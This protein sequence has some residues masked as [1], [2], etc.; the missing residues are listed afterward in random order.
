MIKVYKQKDTEFEYGFDLSPYVCTLS[1]KINDAWILELEN[2]LDDKFKYIVENSVIKATTP[3]G[4][5]L[6]RIISVEKND[7]SIKANARPIFLDSANEVFIYDKRPTNKT[8]QATLNELT[9][10]TKYSGESNIRDAHTA[11][12]CMKNLVECIAG[13]DENSFLNRWGGEIWYDDFKIHIDDRLGTDNNARVEFGF[14]LKSIEESID[15]SELV[16][17]IIPIAFNGRHL[18]QGQTVDSPH[19]NKYPLIYIK[20]IKYEYIKLAEDVQ[21]GENKDGIIVCKNL[22]TLYETL[23]K[24]AMKDFNEKHIDFPKI[25]YNVD[26]IDLSKTLEYELIK[27]LL[28]VNLGDTVHIKHRRLGIETI[29]RVIEIEYDCITKKITNMV[30]GDYVST[31]FEK[32]TDVINSAEKVINAENGSVMADKIQGIINLSKT[33]LK[34]QKNIAQRQDVRAILFEDLDQSSP[35]FGA[36]CIGTQG[37]QI[38]KK[39]T[40]SNDGWLWNTAINFNS[41]IADYIVTGIISDKNGKNYWN[42]DTGE[43]NTKD[44]IAT[45]AKIQGNIK[46][47]EGSIGGWNI[48]P[49]GL[50]SNS[51]KI[52]NSGITNIY[53]WADLYI[54]RL[55]IMGTVTADDDMIYHYDFNKDGKIS[56]ADYVELKKRLKSM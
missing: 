55:I 36:L 5:Q 52:N 3:Y 44:M 16:T 29:A 4:D 47:N 33:S 45:N 12:F 38:S 37:I 24:E 20:P 22:E 11:Y 28:T 49:S 8:G 31:Y 7:T 34:A 46:A 13:D 40:P 39:R 48:S 15:T 6:F 43:F 50:A 42:L 2:K 25:S 19:I 21:D 10:G 30:I 9:N 23:K 32:A 56:P 54:V 53:T 17:R 27:D 26:M 1:M 41:I 14:N 51:V 35:T 18:P